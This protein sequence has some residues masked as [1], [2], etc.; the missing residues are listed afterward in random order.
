MRRCFR[1]LNYR[2]PFATWKRHPSPLANKRKYIFPSGV[3]GHSRTGFWPADRTV[4]TFCVPLYQYYTT[5]PVRTLALTRLRLTW[6]VRRTSKSTSAN[7]DESARATVFV[8]PNRSPIFHFE[9]RRRND[10]T[11]SFSDL[12]YTSRFPTISVIRSSTVTR[13][14]RR[15]RRFSPIRRYRFQASRTFRMRS[16]SIPFGG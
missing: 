1:A 2:R 14:S 6:S 13:T 10:I 5:R 12:Q 11:V 3:P 16:R 7:F 4:S 8:H 9:R 15:V